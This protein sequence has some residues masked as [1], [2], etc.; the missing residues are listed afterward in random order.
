MPG[1]ARRNANQDTTVIA[2]RTSRRLPIAGC[3]LLAALTLDATAV[4]TPAGEPQP[5]RRGRWRPR[6]AEAGLTAALAAL[7]AVLLA[8]A[9]GHP[10]A[11]SPPGH[12]AAT[13]PPGRLPPH[14]PDPQRGRTGSRDVAHLPRQPS[15]LMPG[16]G[17][18]AR[19][20]GGQ[21]PQL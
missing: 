11:S 8:G 9:P 12:P 18:S 16:T 4:L 1:P 7:A 6:R 21:P 2:R 17:I 19:A 20:H 3:R 13:H 15:F 14:P 10:Q 5:G